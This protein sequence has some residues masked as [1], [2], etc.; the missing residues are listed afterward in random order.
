MWS[1]TEERIGPYRAGWDMIGKGIVVVLV[2]LTMN[3]CGVGVLP[4]AGAV[5]GECSGCHTMHNSQ[6]GATMKLDSTPT[7]GGSGECTDCHADTRNILLRMDCLGCHAQNPNG[8]ANVISGIPQIAHNAGTDLA[9]GNFR[10]VFVDDSYGHNVHGFG[11]AIATDGTLGNTPPGYDSAFDPSTAGYDPAYSSGQIMCAGRN[12]CHGDRDQLGQ[13]DALRGAH[14]EDDTAL[15]YGAGFTEGSQGST[16]GTSYR[17]LYKIRGAEDSDWEAT[18]GTSDHNEYRGAT[19]D[20]GRAS[21]TWADIATMSQFCAECHGNFHSGAGLTTS[22]PWIRHPSDAV[23]PNAAPYSSYTSYSV[24]APVARQTIADATTQASGSVTPG[25]D[26][27]FCLSCHRAHASP[28][29]DL[30]RW[31]YNTC[32]NATPDVSCGCFTCHSDKD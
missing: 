14:H 31:D 26:V 16:V 3:V 28:Y 17:F 27:V 9:A 13:Y 20:S 24:L 22:G 1:L 32:K 6:A 11:S 10:N 30:L 19:F 21:Q 18:T 23:L 25:T 2:G 5:S 7:S 12:G 29:S 8:S 4:A 15:Q